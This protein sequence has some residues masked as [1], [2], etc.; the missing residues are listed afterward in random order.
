M[1]IALIAHDKKKNDMIKLAI[2]YKDDEQARQ[3]DS[4]DCKRRDS[5]PTYWFRESR[6]CPTR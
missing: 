3:H 6:N 5:L 2:E 1:K 4:A